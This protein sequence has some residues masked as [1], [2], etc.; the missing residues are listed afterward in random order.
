MSKFLL[1]G[2]RNDWKWGCVRLKEIVLVK[3]DGARPISGLAPFYFSLFATDGRDGQGGGG[4]AVMRRE[5][6]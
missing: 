5:W 6:P 4:M 3:N 1:S 2:A